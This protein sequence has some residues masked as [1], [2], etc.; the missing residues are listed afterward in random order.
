M[1]NCLNP[2]NKEVSKLIDTFGHVTTS[3]IID[4]YYPDED[5]TYNQVMSNPA[6]REEYGIHTKSEAAN[7]LGKRFSK[8]VSNKALINLKSAISK[9]NNSQNKKVYRLFNVKQVGQADLYTWE[10]Q[11]FEATL[12]V[13]AKLARAEAR[14][15]GTV[16]AA[17]KIKELEKKVEEQQKPKEGDQLT[18]FN[19]NPPD[20]TRKKVNTE[21]DNLLVRTLKKLTIRTSKGDKFIEF[22]N[23]ES[24][25]NRYTKDTG[26]VLTSIG[27]ADIMNAVIAYVEDD[28]VTLPEEAIHFI[29]YLIKDTP[30]VKD[31]INAVDS[32]GVSVF[33]K[34]RLYIDNYVRYVEKYDGDIDKANTEILVKLI[35]HFMYDNRKLNSY[36]NKFFSGIDYLINKLL[37]VFKKTVKYA[38]R[39]DNEY[40]P[41]ELRKALGIIDAK[42]TSQEYFDT[43]DKAILDV[44]NPITLNVTRESPAERLRRVNKNLKEL[45]QQKKN[46]LNSLNNKGKDYADYVALFNK[47]GLAQSAD[48]KVFD[49]TEE[50]IINAIREAD[51]KIK[52]NPYAHDIIEHKEVLLRLMKHFKEFEKNYEETRIIK[53]LESRLKYINDAIVQKN[54]EEGLNIFLFGS[55][56]IKDKEYEDF[57]MNEYGAI[58]D[59]FR[60]AQHA[61]KYIAAPEFARLEHI[62]NFKELLQLYRPIIE[63]VRNYNAMQG[64]KLF[65]ND[66]LRNAKVNKA[67]DLITEYTTEIEK[68]LGLDIIHYWAKV[69]GS[70]AEFTVSGQ[71]VGSTFNI[72]HAKEY[73]ELLSHYK[74]VA[75]MEHTKESWAGI[76]QRKLQNVKNTIEKAYN[77][78][79]NSMYKEV[80]ALG[81]NDLSLYKL[82]RVVFQ[83]KD[84]K[85]THYLNTRYDIDTWEKA[86]KA[87]QQVMVN[88]IK[89]FVLNHKDPKVNSIV[90]PDTYEDVRKIFEP[91]YHVS[92]EIRKDLPDDLKGLWILRDYFSELWGT[93]HALNSEDINNIEEVKKQR[94]AEMSRYEYQMWEN[95]NI[96]TYV[97]MDGTEVTYF[98]GEL[99]RPNSK[100]I[101][102]QYERMSAEEKK[103]ADYFFEKSKELKQEEHLNNYSYEFYARAP[104]ISKNTIDSIVNPRSLAKSIIEGIKDAFQAR[105]D[106]EL[107]NRNDQGN[108]IKMPPIRYNKKLEDPDLLSTD[109]VRMFNM[110]TG[111]VEH[112]KGFLKALPELQGMVDAVSYG[113]VYRDRT[114]KRVGETPKGGKDSN[115]FKAMEYKMRTIVYGDE[116]AENMDNNKVGKVDLN[117]ASGAVKKYITYLNLSG[118]AGAVVTSMVSSEIDK[119]VTAVA[120]DIIDW[121]DYK[122]G[123]A[124]F[125]TKGEALQ[126]VADWENPI[127]KFKVN[128]LAVAMQLT[129]D[130]RSRISNTKVY[131]GVR[132]ALSVVAP[133]SLWQATELPTVLP[134]IPAVA[135]RYRNIDGVWYSK[136]QYI[137]LFKQKDKEW[138]SKKKQWDEASNLYDQITMVNGELDFGDAPEHIVNAFF[139][140]TQYLAS[141]M[142]QKISDVSKGEIYTHWIGKLLTTH[143]DWLLQTIPKAIKQ[144]HFNWQSNQMEVGYYNRTSTKFYGRVINQ[145]LRDTLKSLLSI[146]LSYQDTVDMF[147]YS[148][149][150]QN[151]HLVKNFYRVVSHMMVA[152]LVGT[153]AYVLQGLALSDDDDEK[154]DQDSLWLEIASFLAVKVMI[155]Q[156]AKLSFKDLY[157]LLQNPVGNF[158]RSFS[159]V[160]LAQLLLHK[161]IGDTEE[162]TNIDP[163]KNPDKVK[164]GIYKG[165]DKNTKEIV[166]RIPYV[167]GLYE[168]YYGEYINKLLI[169]REQ[170]DP[171]IRMAKAYSDKRKA[172]EFFVLNDENKKVE[173]DSKAILDA[174]I[175]PS[176]ILGYFLGESILKTMD[177]PIYKDPSSFHFRLPTKKAQEEF[178]EQEAAK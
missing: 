113:E 167:K 31:I 176:R 69:N 144:E 3:K 160:A 136:E 138:A 159:I 158:D 86:R 71:D 162:D 66:D 52:V 49:L 32:N 122:Y 5:F 40:Y 102:Q 146:K 123:Q 30:E 141:M 63:I 115:L 87:Y 97:R 149:K 130:V 4:N 169:K 177:K 163:N 143:I 116:G 25:K 164:K 60:A 94:N 64:G 56:N 88:E 15:T 148:K 58:H 82:T 174:F 1:K 47:S 155:E 151:I 23:L 92:D 157:N 156:N 93:W 125:F 41:L 85:R 61:K 84:G 170:P 118:N 67:L 150:P 54:Y 91:V 42:I 145:F 105:P 14:N 34:T 9:L 68:F 10:L 46:I 26:K 12:D 2:K 140:K 120:G 76:F 121:E 139:T 104:Q 43:T 109:I 178:N 135:N 161:L 11:G 36:T 98:K 112:R 127:K 99:S 131:R 134:L 48:E 175:I 7:L 80:Q 72:E 78:R 95:H 153:L 100:Y 147:D 38:Y 16:Q 24:Y 106:D 51:T 62:N 50:R 73:T 152:T 81:Y 18:L 65:E 166:I 96:D 27:V 70:I 77:T 29:I 142:S 33:K 173:A 53:S 75:G 103:L 39:L 17:D 83:F 126:V 171:D 28:G 79:I 59:L 107:Y 22:E 111:M 119:I 137:A 132:M 108:V 13:K 74:V 20:K 44:T 128:A 90:I 129:G 55:G 168:S 172:I 45:I 21:L 133:F 89:A 110:Y 57:D 8:E 165:M 35:A 114:K 117:K 19:L 101:N 124:Q 154:P 6:I 37:S